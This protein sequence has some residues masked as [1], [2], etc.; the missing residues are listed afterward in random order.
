MD[1]II[2][3]SIIIH[4]LYIL[5]LY[6]I[7]DFVLAIRMDIFLKKMMQ[8]IQLGIIVPNLL[9]LQKNHESMKI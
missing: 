2:C 6:L 8:F 3:K 4:I 9:Y 5:K 7:K 1:T